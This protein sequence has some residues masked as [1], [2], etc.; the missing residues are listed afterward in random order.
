MTERKGKEPIGPLDAKIP[1]VKKVI[2]QAR[3]Q[4]SPTADISGVITAFEDL[5]KI[6]MT[7]E[8]NMPMPEA[9]MEELKAPEI[10]VE[11][12]L[13]NTAAVKVV[14]HIKDNGK[15]SKRQSDIE[16]TG[17]DGKT[18]RLTKDMVKEAAKHDPNA[19]WLERN[20]LVDDKWDKLVEQAS[21]GLLNVDQIDKQYFNGGIKSGKTTETTKN[22]KVQE[23]A[24]QV[25]SLNLPGVKVEIVNNP[26]FLNRGGKEMG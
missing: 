26:A 11:D 4:V 13:S 14:P 21:G 20:G 19:T 15:P 10:K 2:G 3:A 23:V 1:E 16:I 9:K 18:H 12:V 5:N 24:Q 22:N 25:E 7:T 6:E 8:L 17:A